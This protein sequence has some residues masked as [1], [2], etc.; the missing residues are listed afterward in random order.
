[1]PDNRRSVGATRK[2]APP[3]LDSWQVQTAKARF[4]VL[5]WL[6]GIDEGLVHM[7]VLTLGEIRK[8][9]AG[10]AQGKRR[11]QL[12][13]WLEIDLSVRFAGRVLPIE[14]AVAL[15]VM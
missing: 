4:S 15:A 14:R 5:E 3:S 11:S 7:S 1:M 10:M 12:E 9:V 8:G 2:T 6:D 13:D